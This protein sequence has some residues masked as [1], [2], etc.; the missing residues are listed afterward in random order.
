M[1]FIKEE[2]ED[3]KIDETFK[4]KQEDTEEQTD[5]M[6]LNEESQELNEKEE[7]DQNENPDFI[8]GEKSFSFSQTEN[9]S[10][11]KMRARSNFTCQECGKSFS[12]PG[13]LKVHMRIHTGEKPFTCQQ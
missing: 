8:T 7:K 13:N 10:S 12:Q 4:V 11:Q 3:L 5:L 1:E 2:S 6:A 9:S